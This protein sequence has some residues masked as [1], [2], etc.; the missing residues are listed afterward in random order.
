MPAMKMSSG[1]C[2]HR[3]AR[4]SAGGDIEAEV[5]QGTYGIF[6]VNEGVIDSDDLDSSMLNTVLV[7]K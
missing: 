4:T 2:R 3:R 7:Q 5:A 1:Q 6:G